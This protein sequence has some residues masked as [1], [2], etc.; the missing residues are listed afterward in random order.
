[1]PGRP[2]LRL[3]LHQDH[4]KVREVDLPRL[5]AAQREGL[6]RHRALS[7]EPAELEPK[8]CGQ[9]G[10]ISPRGE[11]DLAGHRLMLSP[12]SGKGYREGRRVLRRRVEARNGHVADQRLA[13]AACRSSHPVEVTESDRHVAGL[14]LVRPR[15][16]DPL[17]GG[18]G[19]V[20]VDA[21]RH[22]PIR[23][24]PEALAH[25]GTGSRGVA[26]DFADR[27]APV[28]EPQKA[29]IDAVQAEHDPPRHIRPC[30][31]HRSFSFVACWPRGGGTT[32]PRRRW[33]AE[34]DKP[35]VFEPTL[36]ASRTL[37]EGRTHRMERIEGGPWRGRCTPKVP[38]SRSA[39]SV[40]TASSDPCELRM[41][42]AP[43]APARRI[44]R[45]GR[46][47]RGTA[48]SAT[49]LL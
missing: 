48:S 39:A 13:V 31:R 15:R 40:P 5:R 29:H 33:L 46:G 19:E 42:A 11:G 36:D 3:A 32:E 16:R 43:G 45:F 22:R 18:R 26:D 8:I 12:G 2:V 44:R 10:P 17:I 47:C 35:P 14:Q 25:I 6:D 1:M 24:P 38:G 30:I 21:H 49:R 20:E 28:R 9:P 4:L 34:A 7:A 27:P 37:P 41:A 23:H